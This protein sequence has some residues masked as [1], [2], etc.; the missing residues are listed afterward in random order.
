MA[1]NT[2]EKRE[3]LAFR[4]WRITV[5]SDDG[6]PIRYEEPFGGNAIDAKRR[7]W[8]MWAR[9]SFIVGKPL[10]SP[11]RDV[12]ASLEVFDPATGQYRMVKE[13]RGR[14]AHNAPAPAES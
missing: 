1:T 10:R 14:L 3:L 13:K 12:Y 4:N 7:A 8:I 9:T 6:A 2:L 11:N 5:K